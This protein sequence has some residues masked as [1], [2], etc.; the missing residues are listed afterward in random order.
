MAQAVL[1]SNFLVP[2]S[3]FIVELV[4]FLLVLAALKR[5]ILPYVNTALN[6]RQ[7]TIRQ[8]L[9]DAEEAKRRS[10]EAEAEY[11][12]AVEEARSQARR[13]VDEANKLGED[14]RNQARERAEAEYRRIISRAQADI[15]ASVR[16]ASE[17]LRGQVGDLVVAVVERVIGQT[18]DEQAQRAFIDRTIAEIE[19]GA[20]GAGVAR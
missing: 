18:M 20:S 9:E 10:A 16:R 17:E 11:R 19:S 5:W 8:A 6:E 12:R 14:M 7:Q 1:A 3:T 13:V 4:A 2:N 15:D